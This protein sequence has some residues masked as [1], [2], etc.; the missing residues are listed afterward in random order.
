M[1][2][3]MDAELYFSQ[4]ELDDI[5]STTVPVYQIVKFGYG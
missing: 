4:G 1:D 2:Y 5:K 3:E